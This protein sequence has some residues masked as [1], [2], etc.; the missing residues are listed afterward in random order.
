MGARPNASRLKKA[1]QSRKRGTRSS[2]VST[3]STA[4][5]GSADASASCVCQEQLREGITSKALDPARL[6]DLA[7][8]AGFSVKQ[9]NK[10]NVAALLASIREGV[11]RRADALPI[12]FPPAL[13]FDPR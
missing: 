7:A 5:K 9:A 6:D 4:P 10:A 3:L 8:T 1:K 13:V 11:M 2:P 12:E